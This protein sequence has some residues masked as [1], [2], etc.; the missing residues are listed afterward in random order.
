MSGRHLKCLW[1][2]AHQPAEP[3]AA[4]R[5]LLALAAGGSLQDATP[6]YGDGQRGDEE[7]VSFCAPSQAVVPRLS[8][9]A[10]VHLASF[11]AEEWTHGYCDS[12]QEKR[13][14]TESSE[15]WKSCSPNSTL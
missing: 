14:V 3:R 9:Q 11:F 10:T 2:A 13:S 4:S 5:H 12:P 7:I 8:R 15:N 6:D 1:P